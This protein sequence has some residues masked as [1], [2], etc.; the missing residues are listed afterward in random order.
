MRVLKGQRLICCGN[1]D[2]F[3]I[4]K[5]R[6]EVSVK[7]KISS[8][9]YLQSLIENFLVLKTIRKTSKIKLFS[10]NLSRLEKTDST[11]RD[12]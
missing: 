7:K 11:F 1:I 8:R 12:Q 9:N 5:F 2:D 3:R 10:D 4:D 6:S